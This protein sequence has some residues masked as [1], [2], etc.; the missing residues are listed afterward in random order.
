[1]PR[2]PI[3]KT[4]AA[5][6]AGKVKG[7]TA[8]NARRRFTRAAQ[9]NIKAAEGATGVSKNRLMTLA[10][11]DLEKALATYDPKT[12]QPFSKDIRQLASSLDINLE[13]E[14]AKLGALKEGRAAQYRQAAIKASA[15]RLEGEL[16]KGEVRRQAIAKQLFNS[17][18][19]QRIIGGNVDVW[20]EEAIETRIVDGEE[21]NVVNKTKM[22]QALFKH[23][24]VNNL[25]D[26][27]EAVEKLEGVD[28]YKKGDDE[29]N[30]Y[31]V[32]KLQIQNKVADN[33]L[34]A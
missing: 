30:I 6:H 23:Y 3:P 25:A 32:V 27:L 19:G 12:T 11:L 1:M 20:R 4:K 2:L 13:Q 18:I 8:Y 14:R 34:V 5:S 26:L 17:S 29:D 24:N 15:E 21:K 31:E 22:M 28:L 10:R 33:T 9:R 7:D 16:G